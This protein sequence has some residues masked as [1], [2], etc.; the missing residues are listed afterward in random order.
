MVGV[1]KGTGHPLLY[2]G[3]CILALWGLAS[4]NPS[5][6]SAPPV[7]AF[8]ELLRLA[9]TAAPNGDLGLRLRRLLH[10]PFVSNEAWNSGARPHRPVRPGSGPVLRAVQW[11]IAGGRQFDLIRRV[12]T[13]PASFQTELAQ[14]EKAG[15]EAV[16]AIREQL[17]LL[18]GADVVILNEADLGM[19]RSGY[20][21]V[22]RE[23]A[24]ALKMN[25]V[26]GVEFVE[27]D[28]LELGLAVPELDGV[29]KAELA[30]QLEVDP[31]RYK[32]LHGSAILSRYPIQSAR[33]HR[34][35]ACYDWYGTEKKEIAELEKGRRLAAREVF[36]ERIARELRHGNRIALI[37]EIAVPES[38]T[39]FL[40]VVAA[41]L[42]GRSP[43]KCRRAQ[44]AD[45]LLTLV[46]DANP[47]ILGGDLNTT[48]LSAAPTSVWLEINKR[49]SNPD[50]WIRQAVFRFAI[51]TAIAE[52]VLLPT[53]YV[54]NLHDPTVR[55]IPLFASNPESGLFR[56]LE[57]FRFR[58]GYAF[59]F[60]GEKT[61]ANSNE[62]G[63]KGF[64]P[65]FEFARDYGGLIG[66]YKLDWFLV[67]PFIR[68]PRE[69]N[70][71]RYF[72]P[73]YARTLA[74]LNRSIAQQRI[75]DH[76]PIMV[77]LQLTP[78]RVLSTPYRR[79]E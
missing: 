63:I 65:T 35:V 55:D 1:R 39:G 31:A 12:F 27:V 11:N 33:I 4:G 43:P 73:V 49:L 61:L 5:A 53:N 62:R 64:K 32:G 46:G 29:L 50:F 13:D 30:N 60:R 47:V 72:A 22:A 21:D 41:Q 18:Q 52:A 56:A 68:R 54:K 16:P 23:L 20:R 75:S 37:A 2:S 58:D 6:Y 3:I 8:E 74:E 9:E 14:A 44:M 15:V 24:Q 36:L 76:D 42:E 45:L 28:R 51:P 77:D 66:T 70:G 59:D 71:S 7:L 38:P 57:R 40:T 25:Y 78:D 48:G 34:L 17:Q 19:G 26:F 10:T 69:R 79:S 67:K